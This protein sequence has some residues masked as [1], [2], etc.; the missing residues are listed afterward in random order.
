[1]ESMLMDVMKAKDGPLVDDFKAWTPAPGPKQ[2]ELLAAQ[3]LIFG[4]V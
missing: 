3:V 1:M 2:A 4:T